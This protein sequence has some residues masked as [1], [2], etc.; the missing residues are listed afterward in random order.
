MHGIWE[1]LQNKKNKLKFMCVSVHQVMLP[2][3][4]CG[5]GEGVSKA[6]LLEVL[7][8]QSEQ[9]SVIL[10]LAASSRLPTPYKHLP[11]TSAAA[12]DRVSYAAAASVVPDGLTAYQLQKVDYAFEKTETPY[13]PLFKE[14]E[15]EQEPLPDMSAA[16]PTQY[17]KIK[18]VCPF[19][20]LWLLCTESAL[21]YDIFGA[22]LQTVPE[23]GNKAVGRLCIYFD[24]I[25]PGNARRF[26]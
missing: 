23:T 14:L 15:A 1:A 19:A 7:G 4:V 2:A 26:S 25:T 21:F 22:S 20:L 9:L 8:F 12:M 17:I 18:Y 11:R 10:G 24:D 13:G 3:D 16:A 6:G 5:G